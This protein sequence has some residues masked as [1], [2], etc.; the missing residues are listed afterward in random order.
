MGK[1]TIIGALTASL[2]LAACQPGPKAGKVDAVRLTAADA[3]SSNWMSYG[4]T[5]S[6][7]RYSPLTQ[8]NTDTV[9]KLGVAWSHEFDTDRGQEATP[10]IIDGTLYTTTNWSTV[11]R[12]SAV[13]APKGPALRA[14]SWARR[15]KSGLPEGLTTSASS[16]VPGCATT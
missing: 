9:A 12:M 15:S 11:L 1:F 10:L 6:E 8:V 4:R 2:L 7:Q 5:Y 14:I 3:D 16:T 13:K